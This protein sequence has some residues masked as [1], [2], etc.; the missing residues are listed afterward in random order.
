MHLYTYLAI[1]E[2]ACVPVN[3]CA[4]VCM[5]P[6]NHP[7]LSGFEGSAPSSCQHDP[8]PLTAVVHGGGRVRGRECRGVEKHNNEGE[9]VCIKYG[10]ASQVNDVTCECMCKYGVSAS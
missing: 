5:C 1:C 7:A 8:C 3:L 6:S 9:S 4:C 10:N 2:I